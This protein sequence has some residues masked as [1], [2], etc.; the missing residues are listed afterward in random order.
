MT[1]YPVYNK[2]RYP[3]NHAWQLKSYY[4]T[5]LGSYGRS[6]IIRHEKLRGAPP[7]GGLTMTS[8]PVGNK[9]Y[10]YL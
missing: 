8:C 2:P 9:T 1:S 4:R 7:G 5:L 10:S 3:G 6:F